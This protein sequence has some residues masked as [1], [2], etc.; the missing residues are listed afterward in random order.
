MTNF[1]IFFQNHQINYQIYTPM[2]AVHDNW[3]RMFDEN[4]CNNINK[5]NKV[6]NKSKS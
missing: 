6:I 5:I 1:S 2:P 3:V 4:I